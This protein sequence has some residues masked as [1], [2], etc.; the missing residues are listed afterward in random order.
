MAL[1][2]DVEQQQVLFAGDAVGLLQQL[3]ALR[4]DGHRFVRQHVEAG[5]DAFEDVAGLACVV[6][7]DHHEVA[8]FLRE[9][10]LEEIVALVDLGDPLGRIVGAGV[11]SLDERE[12]AFEFG[13]IGRVDADFRGHSFELGLLHQRGVEMAG[14]QGDDPQRVR[15]GGRCREG[16]GGG[17][18]HEGLL[19]KSG[20]IRAD[21]TPGQLRFLSPSLR[22][23]PSRASKPQNN[24]E[25]SG[26]R[27][28]RA[29]S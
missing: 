28:G 10:F 22:V 21:H 5:F 6:A 23:C 25:P 18:L 1:G 9:H 13:T 26:G 16:G 2:H 14:I 15:G 4:V 17:E 20:M 8:G 11:E 3:H 7:G 19:H 24:L 12:V 29:A 27:S